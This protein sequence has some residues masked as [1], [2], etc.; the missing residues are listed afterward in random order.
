MLT[1]SI[2]KEDELHYNQIKLIISEAIE[3]L[4]EDASEPQIVQLKEKFSQWK[5]SEQSPRELFRNL[6]PQYNTPKVSIVVLHCVLIKK[7]N[8][9]HKQNALMRK[10]SITGRKRERAQ[11]IK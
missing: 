5:Q 9:T 6:L 11:H 4:P 8:L 2:L 7:R 1:E 10:R 3:S